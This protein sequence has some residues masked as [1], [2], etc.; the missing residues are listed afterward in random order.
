MIPN[1]TEALAE[2]ISGTSSEELSNEVISKTKQCLIDW[3]GC[4][5]AGSQEEIGKI[6]G[7]IAVQDS[8]CE[9]ATVFGR[10][11]RSSVL[12]AALANGASSHILELDDTHRGAVY[13]PGAVVIPAALAL[14]EKMQIS[15]L[16]LIGAIAVGYDVSIRIGEGIGLSHYQYWHTTA[17][18]GHFGAAAASSKI[19]ALTRQQALD[20]LGN[21]GTQASG[22]WQFLPDGA[23]TKPLHPGKAAADGLL[24]ALLAQRG[25]TG[26]GHILEGE[27]GFCRA[28]STDYDLNR[29]IAGLGEHPKILEVSFKPY[30]SCRHTHSALDAA[31]QIRNRDKLDYRSITKITVHTYQTAIDI[32]GRKDDYPPKTPT[33]AKFCLPYCI[34]AALKH[35]KLDLDQFSNA[36][37]EDRE[38]LALADRVTLQ[39]SEKFNQSYP[40][41]WCCR[42]EITTRAGQE[43]SCDIQYPKGDPENPLTLQEV[44]GKFRKLA[45]STWSDNQITGFLREVSE[46]ENINDV[47]VL[48]SPENQERRM[49]RLEQQLTKQESPAE[50]S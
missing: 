26:P 33:Q 30:P 5:L 8:H 46:L 11:E 15:G 29:M 22:L 37:L 49:R 18:C 16:E 28:T 44:E 39:V 13:H 45:G 3:L 38:I 47:S 9:D 21:A 19:L 10:S 27:R 25:F 20:A 35:G 42:V 40:A 43:L 4:A 2:Y 36:A 12:M 34:A 31:L 17:T 50:Q 24:A 48:C 23:M 41:S 6:F 1:V 14:G 32:A 7:E